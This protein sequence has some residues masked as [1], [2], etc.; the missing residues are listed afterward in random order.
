MPGGEHRKRPRG[1]R[2]AALAATLAFM[3]RLV[4]WCLVLVACPAMAGETPESRPQEDKTPAPP[5]ASPE[6][7]LAQDSETLYQAALAEIR[8]RRLLRARSLLCQCLRLDPDHRGAWRAV[9]KVDEALVEQAERAFQR[10]DRPAPEVLPAED[11]PE[12]RP[13]EPAR[14]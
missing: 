9:S 2:G 5:E 11:P 10:H 4:V 13:A 12:A 8:A 14:P 7:P 3:L 6:P 1:R